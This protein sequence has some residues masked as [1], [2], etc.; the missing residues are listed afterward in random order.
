MDD[1][2]EMQTAVKAL[3][4]EE[5]SGSEMQGMCE[6]MMAKME[7]SSE[8]MKSVESVVEVAQAKAEWAVTVAERRPTHSLQSQ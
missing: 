6:K 4:V 1:D 5:K 3:S 7:G 8:D 2:E